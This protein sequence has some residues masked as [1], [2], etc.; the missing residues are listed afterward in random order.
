[1]IES[2]ITLIPSL[3]IFGVFAYFLYKGIKKFDEGMTFENYIRKHPECFKDGK[4]SCFNCG[5]TN[6]HLRT[7][8]HLITTTVNSHVCRSCGIE[9][10][11]TQTRYE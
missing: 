1:M 7:L 4:V 8:G 2:L 5:S 6:I 9:V 10:Y 11:K 3:L